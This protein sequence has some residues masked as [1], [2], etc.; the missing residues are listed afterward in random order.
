M[1]PGLVFRWNQPMEVGYIRE[2]SPSTLLS[3]MRELVRPESRLIG[4]A[5][6]AR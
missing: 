4:H 6:A 3:R 2:Y 5:R 1:I